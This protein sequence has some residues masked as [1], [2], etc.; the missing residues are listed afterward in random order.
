MTQFSS[1]DCIYIPGGNV[2]IKCANVDDAKE[3]VNV[4]HVRY[5]SDNIFY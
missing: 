3:C 4:I 5:F 1:Y 2:Y